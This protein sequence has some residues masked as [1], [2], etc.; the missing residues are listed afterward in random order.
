V[1]RHRPSSTRLSG[2]CRCYYDPST[3]GRMMRSTEWL[4]RHQILVYTVAV[5]LAVGIGVGQPSVAPLF[6]R[7]ITPFWRCCCTQPSSR[8]RSADFRDAFT[9]GRFMAGALGLNFLVVPV[10]VCGLTRFLR[11]TRSYSSVRSWYC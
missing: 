2:L 5:A 1:P 10:V 7:L 9:N 6:E 8:F 4:Q 11:R 3:N